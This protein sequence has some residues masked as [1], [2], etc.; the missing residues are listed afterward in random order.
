MGV[1]QT[2]VV[3]GTAGSGKTNWIY[4]QLS[5]NYNRYNPSQQ[6]I[7]YFNPG[8]GNTPIDQKRLESDF[9]TL[10]TFVDGQ[11]AELLKQVESADFVYIELGFYLELGTS[12]QLLGN[13]PHRKVAVLPPHLQDSEWHSWA[14]E[15]IPGMKIDPGS[16]QAEI[17]RVP[18]TGQVID[19]DS[20]GEFWYEIIHDAYGD[21]IRAKGIFDVSDGRSIY[22]DYVA[23]ITSADF[24]ELD[25]PR[26]LEGRP[27]RF[28]GLEVVGTSLNQA[29]LA[30]TLSDCCLPDAMILQY[31]QQVKQI[32]SEEM[33]P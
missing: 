8:T 28:S 30:Q 25:F 21:V 17:W 11:E 4:Q 20:L 6:K 9:P 3:A 22:G 24:L 23:G 29:A 27:K 2:I 31:Q 7:L 5:S 18:T 19:E 33:T 16:Q 26:Y 32:L 12:A 15:V 13:I 14:D 10:T 1:P